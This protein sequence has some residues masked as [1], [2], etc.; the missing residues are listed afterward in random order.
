MELL[1]YKLGAGA[2]FARARDNARLRKS[3]SRDGPRF[4]FCQISTQD[5]NRDYLDAGESRMHWKFI[6]RLIRCEVIHLHYMNIQCRCD[7][8]VNQVWL[9]MM[10]R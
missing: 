4:K 7:M 8:Q 1:K 5:S 3:G 9:D 2:N 6:C 10:C